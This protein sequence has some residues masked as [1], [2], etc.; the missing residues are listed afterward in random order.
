MRNIKFN[1]L[2]L[3]VII[4]SCCAFPQR[5]QYGRFVIVPDNNAALAAKTKAQIISPS[6][7]NKQ[8]RL[9]KNTSDSLVN[10]HPNYFPLAIGNKWQFYHRYRDTEFIGYGGYYET[11]MD[12]VISVTVIDGKNYYSLAQWSDFLLRYDENEKKI[13]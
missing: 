8:N 9:Y 13:V 5:Q 6:I 3:F 1:V 2:L 7:I 12:S 4:F 10:D 11:Y